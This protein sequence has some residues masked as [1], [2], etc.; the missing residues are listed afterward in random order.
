MAKKNSLNQI[1]RRYHANMKAMTKGLRER[2][3]FGSLV[4][5]KNS[6][7]RLDRLESSMFDRTWIDKIEG[8]IFDL[9]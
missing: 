9:G 8:V 7:L 4:N 2:E 5:G 1:Y 6:Y 3:I